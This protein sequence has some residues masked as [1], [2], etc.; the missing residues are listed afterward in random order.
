MA[1]TC[2][3]D[4]GPAR[5]ATVTPE[6]S[7]N[8]V[9]DTTLSTL[10]FPGVANCGVERA[11]TVQQGPELQLDPVCAMSDG[12][13]PDA[14]MEGMPTIDMPCIDAPCE[15][16]QQSMEELPSTQTFCAQVMVAKAG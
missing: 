9:K 13:C 7:P 14:L 3:P 11:D 4:A 6:N 2:S 12:A 1:A 5:T 15:G 8:R 10:N 16:R